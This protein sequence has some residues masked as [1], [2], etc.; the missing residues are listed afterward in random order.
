MP[1]RLP[2]TPLERLIVALDVPTEGEALALAERLGPNVLWVKV[3]LELFCTA[4]PPVVRALAGMGKRIFLDLNFHDIPNTVAGAVAA[5]SRLPIQLL[6]LHAAAG[7]RAM[8]AACSAAAERSDLGIIAVTRLTSD[9][10]AAAGF[11]DVERF[12]EQ[13]HQA[14]LFGV[15]CPAAAAPL[16]RSRY[17]DSLVRVC[18]GIRP[19]GGDVHDQ[20]HVSTPEGAIAA[21]AHW[22]VVGRAIT[23]AADPAQ[24][25]RVTLGSIAGGGPGI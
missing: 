8:E 20:V 11:S 7:P 5:A 16:L 19:A 24:A 12:A 13:A 25:A 23:R 22:I 9:E 14:G 2:T 15:V 3:G 10:G 1:P 17:G 18:P 4:G 21:G 6:N